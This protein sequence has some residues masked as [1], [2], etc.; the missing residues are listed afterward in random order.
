MPDWSSSL[1]CWEFCNY[2]WTESLTH[3]CCLISLPLSFSFSLSLSFSLHHSACLSFK[4]PSLALQTAVEVHGG[5]NERVDAVTRDRDGRVP[6]VFKQWELTPAG[7]ISLLL[8]LNTTF[9]TWGLAWQSPSSPPPTQSRQ[10]SKASAIRSV[11]R[12]FK[13]GWLRATVGHIIFHL[14]HFFSEMRVDSLA[15][16][17][18]WR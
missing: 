7:R 10:F 6:G 3:F 12:D 2:G 1:W 17:D 18:V 5:K 8:S 13:R 16:G 14:I 4:L 15:R 9:G 11:M